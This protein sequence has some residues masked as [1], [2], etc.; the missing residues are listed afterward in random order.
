MNCSVIRRRRSKQDFSCDIF[1][2]ILK[3]RLS[4]NC[5]NCEKCNGTVTISSNLC[6]EADGL[7]Y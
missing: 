7:Y 5:E 3:K 6:R 1:N 2:K 4:Q